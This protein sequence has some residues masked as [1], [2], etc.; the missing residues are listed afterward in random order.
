LQVVDEPLESV[1]AQ[2]GQEFSIP[3]H[4]D[5]GALEECGIS[6]ETEVTIDLHGIKLRSALNLIFR[7][8]SLVGL[9]Y[10]IQ[11]EVLLITSEDRAN[12][13]LKTVVYDVKA[14]PARIDEVILATVAQDSWV[15]STGEGV[16]QKLKPGV[17]VIAQTQAVHRKIEA[18]LS[19]LQWLE[20]SKTNK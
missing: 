3:I 7:E 1:L 20:E 11:D 5:R 12:E 4:I 16:L 19:Q 9:T 14:F 6:A 15:H 13:S 8:P 10:I 17:L 18:L 2:F